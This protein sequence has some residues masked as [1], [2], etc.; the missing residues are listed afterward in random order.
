MSGPL[1]WWRKIVGQSDAIA[2]NGQPVT[3]QWLGLDMDPTEMSP[4]QLYRCQPYLRTVVSFLSRNVAQIGLHTYERASDTDRKRVR[5]GVVADL[6]GKPNDSTTQYELIESLV[7]NLMLYDE[8]YW[9][10]RDTTEGWRI[11]N[12]PAPWVTAKKGGGVFS[13]PKT[14]VFTRHDDPKQNVEVPAEQVLHFHGWNPD[15]PHS[16]QSPVESL[17]ATLKEQIE[18]AK[19]REQLWKNGGRVG[20][21]ISRPVAATWSKEA[22]GRFKEDW[23]DKWSGQGSQAGGTPILEDGMEMRR[24]GFSAHEEEF[25]EAAKLSLATVASAYHV[26]PMMVGQLDG[27]NYSNAREFHK[28][29]Y[30]D[31]LGPILRML[32]DRLNT[33]LLPMLGAPEGQYVE[34]NIEEKLRGSFEEQTAALQSSVGRP[35]MKVN[36]ARA[37]QNLPAVEGGDEIFVPLNVASG[38]QAS[39]ND[40]GSQNVDP[41]AESHDDEPKGS[42]EVHFKAS[43]ALISKIADI[44]RK[45]FGRQRD[46]VL[47]R[48]ANGDE[49][50]WD[51]ERWEREL[52][53]DLKMVSMSA[54]QEAATKTIIDKGFAPWAFNP[55]RVDAFLTAVAETRSRWVND[56]T[57]DALKAALDDE[58]AEPADVFTRA[59]EQ[60]VDTGS[61]TLATTLES[62]GTVE[63]AK[64]LQDDEGIEMWK[65]WNHNPSSDPRHK[66]QAM[67]GERVGLDER[68]SNGALWPGDKVLGSDGTINC[69]C[70]ITVEAL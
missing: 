60:R 53:A 16:G 17:Q 32:E 14:Y 26:N 11:D 5:D 33:F 37:M 70:D 39:P 21:Y 13:G 15:S 52:A 24:I 10:V 68:F 64:A 62:F 30:S 28:R 20:T 7:S 22:R 45:F 2:P 42:G 57:Y 59:I 50:W 48:I 31:T 34:F 49:D 44:L 67:D 55:K 38:D 47:P 8:A 56:T 18:A 29:L 43:P 65:V 54:V 19:F 12:V 58:E 41:N 23:A 61:A 66:H 69:N 51:G 25:I 6:L 3:Y 1:D 27:A 35:W 46:A 9:W 4:E 36:E 40:T 63:G